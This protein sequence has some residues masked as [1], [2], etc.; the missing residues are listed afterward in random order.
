MTRCKFVTSFLSVPHLHSRCAFPRIRPPWMHMV[1]REGRRIGGYRVDGQEGGRW[2]HASSGPR[3]DCT[4]WPT[5][6]H[7]LRDITRQVSRW[8]KGRRRTDETA[9][10]S[11]SGEQRK[12]ETKSKKERKLKQRGYNRRGRNGWITRE[13]NAIKRPRCLAKKKKGTTA[14]KS[15][16]ER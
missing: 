2:G 12:K 4:A 9:R 14:Q 3:W 10:W 6:Y 11:E 15:R 7:G 5:K 8:A 16:Q 1:V 13:S